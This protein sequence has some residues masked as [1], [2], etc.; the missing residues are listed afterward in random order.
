MNIINHSTE[1]SILVE[2]N[3][4]YKY[5]MFNSRIDSFHT[6]QWKIEKGNADQF[7]FSYSDCEVRLSKLCNF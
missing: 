1:T 6:N 5:K 2:F 3:D 7:V 4:I